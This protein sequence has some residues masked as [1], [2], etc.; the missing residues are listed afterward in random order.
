MEEINNEVRHEKVYGSFGC[1][2]DGFALAACGGDKEP[3]KQGGDTND[4][5]SAIELYNQAE[6]KWLR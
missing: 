5:P 1:N 4:G 2:D 6:E 3:A